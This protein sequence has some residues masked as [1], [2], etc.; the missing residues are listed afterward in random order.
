MVQCKIRE[1]RNYLLKVKMIGSVG[2]R[3]RES[4]SSQKE[5]WKSI[6]LKATVCSS[7]A[8]YEERRR[9]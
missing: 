6:V 2:P 5:G 9:S 3:T 7:S 4:K 1:G 8:K